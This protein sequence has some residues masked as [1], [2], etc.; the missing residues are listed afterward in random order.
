MES[1]FSR[2]PAVT[3]SIFYGK[4]VVSE[5]K[6]EFIMKAWACIRTKLTSLTLNHASSIQDDV[7]VMLNDMS[8]I[9]AGIFPLQDLLGS[10]F[11]MTTS[12]DQ[13]RSAFVDKTTIIKQSEPYLKSKEHLEFVLRERDEKSEKV[14]VT[15]T[16]LEKA[17]KKVEKL[18][19]HRD[20]VKQEVVEMESKVS[21]DKEEFSKYSDVS[22]AT[23]K[24]SK[25]VEKKKQVLEAVLQDLVNYKLY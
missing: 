25:V 22:L 12:Y 1:N 8:G 16:S 21:A 3:M 2:Q 11:R 6:K 4:K 10:F 15:C 23:S 5:L 13:A 7:E 19:A 24:A 20:T 18:K 14:S 9:G 17:R